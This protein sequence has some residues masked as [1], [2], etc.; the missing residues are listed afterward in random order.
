FAKAEPDDSDV[1]AD[2]LRTRTDWRRERRI[3]ARG[4]DLVVPRGVRRSRSGYRN[5]GAPRA[6]VSARGRR[7]YGPPP[8]ELGRATSRRRDS[9]LRT[10]PHPEHRLRADLRE[11]HLTAVLSEQASH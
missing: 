8:A 1:R 10:R 6:R 4:T 3:P 7:R 2:A 5:R 11:A 9:R